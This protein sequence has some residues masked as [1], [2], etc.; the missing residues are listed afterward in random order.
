MDGHLYVVGRTSTQS[1]GKPGATRYYWDP[2][3]WHRVSA[4]AYVIH[5]CCGIPASVAAMKQKLQPQSA[6][7]RAVRAINLI[8]LLLRAGDVHPNP[9]PSLHVAQQN[10]LGLTPGKKD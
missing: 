1:L 9:G 6:R 3:G 2:P 7:M 4:G 10:I 5:H 8:A